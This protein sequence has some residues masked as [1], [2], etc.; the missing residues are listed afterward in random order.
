MEAPCDQ[1][2]AEATAVFLTTSLVPET[3]DRAGGLMKLRWTAADDTYRA[4]KQ[5]VER[6][7][8]FRARWTNPV[9]R[10]RI[11]EVIF[12]VAS[13][14]D[15][16]VA[17]LR[18]TF[19]GHTPVYGWVDL[20]TNGVVESG[21]LSK[22]ETRVKGKGFKGNFASAAEAPTHTT[23]AEESGRIVA[24][25]NS[26]PSS[27]E[28]QID[29]EYWGTTPTAD[30]TRLSAGPH[31]VLVKKVGYQPW[32]LKITLAPGED[33]TISAELEALPVDPS[34]PRITGNR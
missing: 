23:P 7:T 5:S 12:T 18:F 34:K 10:L 22:I 15:A 4:A 30:L 33:R 31:T 9:E 1:V 29:G 28:V 25:F 19:M 6:Y 17:S 20:P 24:R 2:W 16:C 21:L 14:N 11:S 27:A 13:Q 26:T 32:E 8:T 3:S